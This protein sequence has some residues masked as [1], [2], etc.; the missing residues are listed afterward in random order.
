MVPV[1]MVHGTIGFYLMTLRCLK[2]EVF[3][4]S[5]TFILEIVCCHLFFKEQGSQI[6]VNKCCSPMLQ[7]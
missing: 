2:K 5:V 3:M 1:D 7:V 4:N 6:K